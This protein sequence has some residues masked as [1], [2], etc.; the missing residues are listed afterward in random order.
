MAA[1]HKK[2]VQPTPTLEHRSPAY[3]FNIKYQKGVLNKVAN[4]L[5]RDP[6]PDTEIGATD[7]STENEAIS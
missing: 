1:R 7:S 6:M 5:S 2:S 4:A 3:D